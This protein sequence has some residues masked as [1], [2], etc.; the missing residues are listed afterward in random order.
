[1][2]ARV[3]RNGL[4][5]RRHISN[6]ANIMLKTLKKNDVEDLFIYSGGSVMSFIDGLYKNPHFKYYINTNEH[7]LGMAAVGY[8]KTSERTGVC[9]VTSGP[10]VTNMLTPIAD[11]YFDSTPLVVISGQVGQHAIG[12]NAF[13]EAPATALTKPITKWNYLVEHINVLED[14]INEAFKIANEGK[15]GP[16]HIDIPKNIADQ[17]LTPEGPFYFRDFNSVKPQPKLCK[18]KIN[19]VAKLIKKA[20]SPIIYLGKGAKESYEKVRTFVYKSNIPVT[21]TIHG[22]GVFPETHDLS[23]R[24]LGMHGHPAANYAIQQAD[25]IIALGSRFDDRTTGNIEKYAPQ[26]FKAAEEERGGIV[27]VNIEEPELNFVINSHYNFCADVGDW[28]DAIL[29]KINTIHRPLWFEFINDMKEEYDFEM[30]KDEKNIHMEHVLDAIYRKTKFHDAIFTTGVGNHQMQAYQFI[31]S[32]YPGKIIS[33]GSLGV[34][35]AGLPYAIGAQIANPKKMVCLIDGDGSFNMTLND[36]KTIV[37]YNL[38]IKIFIMNNSVQAM[39]NVWEKLFYNNRITAT[40]NN[41]NPNYDDLA[42]SFGISAIKCTKGSDVESFVE[43]VIN[44]DGPILCEFKI[45]NDYC[46]PLVAPGKALDD[47]ILNMDDE[48]SNMLTGIAP[49]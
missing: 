20:K 4:Q 25:L 17:H 45:E 39:V 16:V 29:P 21:S 44:F 26:A 38:P 6:G 35:G 48:T 24:W 22:C 13:Q 46:L 33:S 40:E 47:M 18:N 11:A 43:A 7:N 8:A 12:T 34:M 23:L 1:M 14:V 42:K 49:S 5:Q 31:K 19:E 37:E 41:N 30:K 3:I 28:V 9:M 10:G 32:D 36:L 2:F 27:H 15:K